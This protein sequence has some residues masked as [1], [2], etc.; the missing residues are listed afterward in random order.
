MYNGEVG[1]RKKEEPS[2]LSSQKS[3][4]SAKVGKVVVVGPDFEGDRVAFEKVSEGLKGLN[5]SKEFFV[6][7]IIV[8]FSR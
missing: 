2:G 4:F 3:L 8:L 1:L 6:M 7:N 5:D